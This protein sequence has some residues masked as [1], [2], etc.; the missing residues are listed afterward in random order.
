[1][2]MEDPIPQFSDLISK[3]SPLNLAYIHLVESRIQGG[4]EVEADGALDFA[5]KALGPKTPVLIA[6]GFTPEKAVEA[7][8][9]EHKDAN[10]GIVFGRYF[11]STP[12]LVFRI[13]EGIELNKYERTTFYKARSEEGYTDYPFSKEWESKAN[14]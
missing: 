12:D 6:G 8:D 1:M 14:L 10:V 7:V 11:I 5:F 4:V 3:L 9:V 13:K 2:R